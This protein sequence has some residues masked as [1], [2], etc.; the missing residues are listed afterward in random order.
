MQLQIN[1]TEV[2]AV[3]SKYMNERLALQLIDKEDGSCYTVVTVNLV[4]E[5]LSNKNCA[6]IDTNNNGAR[7]LGWL[8]RNSFGR[9]TGRD[10][11]SG[12]CIYPEFEFKEDLITSKA[13]DLFGEVTK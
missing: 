4:D 10:G 2:I 13:D 11:I 1:G 8:E 9:L 3:F 12:Y 5:E 7:I 6:F